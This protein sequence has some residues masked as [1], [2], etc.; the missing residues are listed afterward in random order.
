[1]QTRK[2]P[3]HA[4]VFSKEL[5]TKRIALIDGDVI[6]YRAAAANETRSIRV[7]HKVTGQVT[8]HAHRTGFKEHIK[9]LFEVDEFDI[10][11]VQTAEDLKFALHAVKTTIEG[12][13]A[14]C[15]A[16]EYEVFLSGKTNFRDDLPLP[17]K[18][19]GSR[20]DNI[21]PLQL[22]ECRDYLVKHHEATHAVDC[23]ADDV[24]AQR[25]YECLKSGDV[26]IVCTIDKDAYGVESW[27]YNWT[28]MD[29]PVRVTGL[30]SIELDD[31][32]V[33]RGIGRKWFYAQWVKGDSVDCFKPSELSGKK[34]GD[35]ACL[36]LLGGC[37]TDK[38]CVEA[39]YKQYK[40]WYPGVVKY[41]CWEGKQHT[42]DAIGLMDLYAACAHMKRFQLDV[43]NTKKLLDKL[44]I[45]YEGS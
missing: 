25:A 33:L 24:L 16:D 26:G 43:F 41:T 2:M 36:K 30:G 20:E 18:Y 12:L 42:T 21:R 15:E 34:F 3:N 45:V 10:E 9:G 35:V 37:K 17:S 6:A 23:E 8:E 38:E 14:T 39:V 13:C 1:M 28:K 29:K 22:K 7:T 4:N 32:K 44:G 5:M 40:T 31:K 11:D 27:L 19:K